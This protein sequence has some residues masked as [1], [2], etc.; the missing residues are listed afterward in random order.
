MRTEKDGNCFVLLVYVTFLN[1]SNLKISKYW[2]YTKSGLYQ[3]V[4]SSP[5]TVFFEIVYFSSAVQNN[6]S[7]KGCGLKFKLLDY[8]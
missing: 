4:Y 6:L 8:I 1:D 3:V 7:E 5:V 2:Y